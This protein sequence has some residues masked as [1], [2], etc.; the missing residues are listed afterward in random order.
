[1]IEL[2]CLSALVNVVCCEVSSVVSSTPTA[3]IS[4]DR[5]V[6]LH[7]VN[8]SSFPGNSTPTASL[9]STRGVLKTNNSE[10]PWSANI[11]PTAAR[12]T[13]AVLSANISENSSNTTPVVSAIATSTRPVYTS[14]SQTLKTVPISHSA[15]ICEVYK[16]GP[17]CEPWI[18][19]QTV[20][21]DPPYTQ[22]VV[23]SVAEKL[24]VDIRPFID[25]SQVGPVCDAMLKEVVCR[26]LYPNCTITDTGHIERAMMCYKSCAKLIEDCGNSLLHMISV[27]TLRFPTLWNNF[28][29]VHVR[30]ADLSCSRDHLS[31]PGVSCLTLVES[32]NFH[33][34]IKF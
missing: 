33:G 20:F 15:G 19:N 2:F 32:N 22:E 1:M 12:S 3:T 8:M 34:L 28:N 21:V 17:L 29:P 23:N 25:E 7:I 13:R 5:Q 4:L 31:S 9:A 6:Q 26:Y 18:H 14:S 11:T 27:V 30:L 24:L 10:N 16:G